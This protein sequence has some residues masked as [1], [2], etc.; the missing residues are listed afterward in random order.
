MPITGTFQIILFE[1]WLPYCKVPK[2]TMD[3]TVVSYRYFQG[4]DVQGADP[5]EIVYRNFERKI[6][7]LVALEK[8]LK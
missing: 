4:D 3:L 5:T 2:A 6:S 7:R 8:I 1:S